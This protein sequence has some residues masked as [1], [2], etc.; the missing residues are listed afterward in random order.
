MLAQLFKMRTSCHATLPLCF[1]VGSVAQH[2]KKKIAKET[3]R[4][5]GRVTY[6]ACI[7]VVTLDLQALSGDRFNYVSAHLI[8]LDVDDL[9]G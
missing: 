5:V 9:S 3:N 8:Y 4:G 2:P 1:F 7:R 6:N